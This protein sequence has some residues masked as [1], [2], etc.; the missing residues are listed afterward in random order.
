[1]M[2]CPLVFPH[3][4]L[5][6]HMSKNALGSF[7]NLFCDLNGLA[8]TEL[9]FLQPEA[10]V[11]PIKLNKK[12]NKTTVSVSLIHAGFFPSENIAALLSRS[13]HSDALTVCTFSMTW[14]VSCRFMSCRFL[15]SRTH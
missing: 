8:N 4:P 3:A 15:F 5:N 10:G 9:N 11:A 7:K 14:D 1:M 2:F 13:D 12:R 6:C